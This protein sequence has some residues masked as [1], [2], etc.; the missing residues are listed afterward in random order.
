MKKAFKVLAVIALVAVIGFSM[1]A[2]GDGTADGGDDDT[3]SLGGEGTF[4][5]GHIP[6]AYNGKY[7]AFYV[8]TG[9][10]D[11]PVRGYQISPSNN[12]V[13]TQISNGK[14]VFPLLT[15][16]ARDTYKGNDTFT[17]ADTTHRDRYPYVVVEIYETATI[18]GLV[19]PD[20]KVSVDFASVTFSNGAA[21]KSWGDLRSWFTVTDIPPEYNG[22]YAGAWVNKPSLP[23]IYGNFGL[24]YSTGRMFL[25]KI[26]NGTVVIPLWDGTAGTWYTGNDTYY[27][28]K[29]GCVW[30]EIYENNPRNISSDPILARIDFKEIKFSNGN[31]IVSFKD[32]AGFWT[33]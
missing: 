18:G 23:D 7:A 3:I 9:P 1:A 28:D 12:I 2:C 13:L 6:S 8:R 24:N 33:E 30:V 29:G 17:T 32:R 19:G 21:A 14:V 22:K 16:N 26:Y 4:T 31:A 5:L 20:C 10:D 15:A 27:R 11:F 25:A